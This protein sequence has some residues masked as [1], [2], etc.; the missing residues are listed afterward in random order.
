MDRG[1]GKLLVKEARCT[2]L[3]EVSISFFDTSFCRFKM[4]LSKLFKAVQSEHESWRELEW[5]SFC[6]NFMNF[7]TTTSFVK[8]LTI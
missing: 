7:Q 2:R 1:F 4:Y 8:K 3:S 5:G 6:E